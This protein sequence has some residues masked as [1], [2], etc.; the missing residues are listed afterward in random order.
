MQDQLTQ[1]EQKAMQIMQGFG[2][3]ASFH[4]YANIVRDVMSAWRAVNNA[5]RAIS[6]ADDRIHEYA[7]KTRRFK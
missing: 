6:R 2:A 3:E 4:D 7:D 5:Y 1:L